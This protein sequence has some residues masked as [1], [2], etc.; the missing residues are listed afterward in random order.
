MAKTKTLM[1]GKKLISVTFLCYA[2]LKIERNQIGVPSRWIILLVEYTNT[3]DIRQ[4]SFSFNISEVVAQ[5]I[6]QRSNYST[7]YDKTG[8]P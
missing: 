4:Q 3:P 5:Q 6:M 1:W 2:V 7:C 8:L